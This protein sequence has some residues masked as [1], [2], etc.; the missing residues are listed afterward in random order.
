MIFIPSTLAILPVLGN[1]TAL[2]YKG[3]TLNLAP[4]PTHTG[5]G[6]SRIFARGLLTCNLL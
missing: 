2:P 3:E 6:D 1:E 4:S 5:R